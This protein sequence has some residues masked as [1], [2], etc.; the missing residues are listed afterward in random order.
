MSVYEERLR[1]WRRDARTANVAHLRATDSLSW[2]D[3]AL[4]GLTAFLSAVVGAGV[5]ASLQGSQAPLGVR[6]GAGALALA[7]AGMAALG[8]YLNYGRRAERHRQASRAYGNLVREIDQALEGPNE[9]SAAV[10]TAIREK[11]DKVDAAAPNVPPAIWTWA[12][13]AVRKEEGAPATVDASSVDRG[14]KPRL[15]RLADRLFR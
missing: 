15:K 5:F 4:G 6:I 8:P 11:I 2:R 3:F 7:A 10:V 14:L 12:V 13:G 1:I 9:L